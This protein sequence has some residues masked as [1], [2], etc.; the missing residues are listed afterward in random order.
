MAG[1]DAAA[2]AVQR[3]QLVGRELEVE[4]VAE[5]DRVVELG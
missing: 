3:L 5:A 1:D 4:V 2:F